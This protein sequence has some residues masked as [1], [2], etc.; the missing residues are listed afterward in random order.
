M[1]E[2]S[3]LAKR[4]KAYRKNI[5]KSQ[6]ELSN[7][8]GISTEELSLIER[9]KANPTLNTMQKIAAHMGITV[10]ELLETEVQ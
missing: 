8:I 10:S 1:P 7:E 5:K 3:A 9:E 4:V 6:F 2:L